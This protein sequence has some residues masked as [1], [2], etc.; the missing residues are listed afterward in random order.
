MHDLD[1]IRDRIALPDLYTEAGYT[2]RRAGAGFSGLCPFHEEK[3]GSFSISLR[4]GVWRA[5]CFGCGW[6]GDVIDFYGASRGVDFKEAAAAL[7]GRCGLAPLVSRD[8]DWKPAPRRSVPLAAQWEKP[9]MPAYDLPTE[10]EL[11]RL[12]DL[13]GL[14]VPGL[15]AAVARGHL[16]MCDWPWRWDADLR[17]RVRGD[18]A[19]RSWVVTDGSGWVAQYRRLDGA[20]YR[21][22]NDADGWR[23]SKSWSTKN[24]SWPVGSPEIGDRWRVLL[25]EGGADLLASYHFLWGLGMLEEVAVCCVLGASNLLA[26]A[27]MGYFADREVRIL[28]DVDEVRPD[29]KSPGLEAASRWQAQLVMARALVT[30]GSLD[31]LTRADGRR[32]KDVNDLALCDAGTLAEAIPLFTEWGY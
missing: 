1:A 16:R 4:N 29:G 6:T 30:V 20:M 3:T 28:M 13:R 23:E 7:A 10:A 24:V 18:D 2:P 22:G 15:R 25:M 21:I 11:E 32:V 26:P 14:Q 9:W 17:R 8:R 31:G 5:K 19:A 12:A 27:A